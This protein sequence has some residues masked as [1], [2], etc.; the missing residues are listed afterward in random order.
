M[1]RRAWLLLGVA[2]VLTVVALRP[3]RCRRCTTS[4]RTPWSRATATAGAR[5]QTRPLG[6]AAR[7]NTRGVGLDVERGLAASAPRGPRRAPA[8]VVSM[9]A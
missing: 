3:L 5:S 1:T 9:D 8:A 4:H 2:L 7:R 6:L